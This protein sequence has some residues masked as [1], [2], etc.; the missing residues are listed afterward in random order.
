MAEL[1]RKVGPF[2]WTSIAAALVFMGVYY[3]RLDFAFIDGDA[4]YEK[5]YK[6][7]TIAYQ[8]SNGE[9]GTLRDW[10]SE[11]KTEDSESDAGPV[12]DELLI[13]V[14]HRYLD[15]GAEDKNKSPRRQRS[16]LRR[17]SET[18]GLDASAK[19]SLKRALEDLQKLQEAHAPPV[20]PE[21]EGRG[22][23][24]AAD[25]DGAEVG[26]FKFREYGELNLRRLVVFSA[27][28]SSPTEFTVVTLS[29]SVLQAAGGPV[30]DACAWLPDGSTTSPGRFS[31]LLEMNSTGRMPD[32]RGTPILRYVQ[33]THGRPYD[34]LVIRCAFPEAVG[35]DGSGGFLYLN[36]SYELVPVFHERRRQL[37]AAAYED[38]AR[39][40]HQYAYCSAPVWTNLSSAHV[41]QWF[42][43]HHTLTGGDIHYFV[44]DNV[45]IDEATMAVLRPLIEAGSLTLINMHRERDFDTWYHTQTLA[46]ND[47][48][49]RARVVA[50]WAIFWDFDEYL[51]LAPPLS[52]AALL[53]Q[54]EAQGAPWVSFGNM[55]YSRM[56]CAPESESAERESEWA[57]ER[58]L[59]RLEGPVCGIENMSHVCEGEMGHRKW[60]ANPRQ[61]KVGA[62][63]RALEVAGGTG[64]TLATEVARINHYS[65]LV[66]PNSA[67]ID[68]LIIKDPVEVNDSKVDGWWIKD[69][70][71][72][73]FAA[74]LK[75][76]A[77]LYDVFHASANEG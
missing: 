62:I 42:M 36:V 66:A 63:H 72:A 5:E 51:H 44:Y 19:E 59:Y 60:I 49:N 35:A 4:A 7:D 38:G 14:I 45:G 39:F 71:L 25:E 22:E 55:W 46:I 17:R 27:Y 69:A 6:T 65:G 12:S 68:C 52:L 13:A 24:L 23:W 11:G 58:M 9:T 28:R 77:Q 50:K 43:Y 75:F 32:P 3:M 53:A 15:E 34:T 73:T 70:E 30:H 21:A 10:T 20:R 74:S 54:V 67:E 16:W 2:I 47:C 40:R 57:V 76:P 26:E 1:Q 48:L 8:K 31:S 64:V 61:V 18:R 56:Y 29:P 33:D 41:K 37:E